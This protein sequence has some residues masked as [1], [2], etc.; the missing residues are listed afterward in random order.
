MLSQKNSPVKTASKDSP[1][2]S[3]RIDA[4]EILGKALEA[5]TLTTVLTSKPQAKG[6]FF[7]LEKVE[8]HHGED[9]T[10]NPD[11]QRLWLASLRRPWR[12][13][14][15]VPTWAGAPVLRIAHVL[16][17]VGQR[18]L[19]RPIIVLDAVELQLDEL[20]YVMEQLK[21]YRESNQS[22][23]IALGLVSQRPPCLSI[24]QAADACLLCLKMGRSTFKEANRTIED[25]GR[26]RFAGSFAIAEERR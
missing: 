1:N 23:I 9:P 18:H 12:A 17:A 25:I 3:P 21:S 14:A 6:E 8:G 4:Q 24:A 26:E 2:D 16:A 7:S 11:W 22:V 10:D 20:S 5:S 19:D 15:I 13:L